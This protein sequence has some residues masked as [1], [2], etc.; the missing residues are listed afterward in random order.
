MRKNS[1]LQ[2]GFAVSSIAAA[3][4]ASGHAAATNGYFTHGIG[5]HNKA[6][7]GAGT[8][9]PEQAIDAATNP[10]A[11]VLV[12]DRLD[13]GLAI[14]S[15]RREFSAGPSQVNG[16]FGAF[17]LEEGTTKSG[18]NWFPIPYVAKNWALEN[19]RAITAVF[20]GRGGMNTDYKGSSATFD[21]DGPWSGGRDDAARRLRGRPHRG[22]SQ[23][24][25]P[26]A[27]L[28]LEDG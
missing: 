27:Q 28:Q 13:V 2:Y 10:A 26:R 12:G 8:A 18:S 16:N 15:P 24:G 9:S 6:L 1:L 22:Q 11:G 25:V 21:P 7:A 23:P 19:D 17:T 3:L 14:F 4:L 20:Y 5:T